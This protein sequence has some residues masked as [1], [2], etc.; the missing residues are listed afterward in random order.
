MDLCYDYSFW[1]DPYRCHIGNKISQYTHARQCL[2]H[3]QTKTI[4]EYGEDCSN[5]WDPR[6]AKRIVETSDCPNNVNETSYC[7]GQDQY[8][9][10]NSNTCIQKTKLCDG[11]IHCIMGDDEETD[12]CNT[13]DITKYPDSA[14]IECF[15]NRLGNYNIKVFAIPCDNNIECLSG[16]DEDNCDVE[17][18]LIATLTVLFFL[19]WSLW[20]CPY[21]WIWKD[22][23]NLAETINETKECLILSEWKMQ[24]C[25]S[26][27]GD[28]LAF[29]KV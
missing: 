11:I 16:R 24:D 1:N 21:V 7:T 3:L 10:K 8:Y 15:E 28:E 23:K 25:H 2:A 4:K 26:L 9:C 5:S 12:I 18:F 17:S 22:Q 29:L 14:T 6:V 13:D 27:K 20:I 19:I